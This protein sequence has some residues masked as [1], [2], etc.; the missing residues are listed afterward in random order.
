MPLS[1]KSSQSSSTSPQQRTQELAE[2]QQQNPRLVYAT[3]NKHDP[4][5]PIEMTFVVTDENG[6]EKTVIAKDIESAEL[7]YMTEEGQHWLQQSRER[8][9]SVTRIRRSA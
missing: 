5:S 3:S 9:S 7:F 1:S 8:A 6:A 4:N 2:S